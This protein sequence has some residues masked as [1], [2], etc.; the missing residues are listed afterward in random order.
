MITCFYPEV[1]DHR[2]TKNPDVQ[3]IIVGCDTT[4]SLVHSRE[5]SISLLIMTSSLL[6][7]NTELYTYYDITLYFHTT[8]ENYYLSTSSDSKQRV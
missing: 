7:F 4:S 8:K 1:K 3:R 2:I 5:P 6:V